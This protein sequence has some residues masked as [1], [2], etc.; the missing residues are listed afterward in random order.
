MG[1]LYK[2]YR[3]DPTFDFLSILVEQKNSD[4]VFEDL[5]EKCNLLMRGNKYNI[6][7]KKHYDFT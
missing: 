5:L 2:K 3:I 6:K 1:S 4:I 7:L